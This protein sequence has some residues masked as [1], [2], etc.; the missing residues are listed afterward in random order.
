MERVVAKTPLKYTL[1]NIDPALWKAVKDRASFE[2]RSLSF[3]LREL[4]RVYAQEGFRIVEMFDGKR[5]P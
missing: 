2:G 4:L 1:R 3:V 5:K